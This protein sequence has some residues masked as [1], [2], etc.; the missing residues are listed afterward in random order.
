MRDI[1]S[2]QH[3]ATPAPA[4][5]L[6]ILRQAQTQG[7]EVL[8]GLRAMQT[9]AFPGATV[10]PGGKLE[11]EDRAWPDADDALTAGK[12]AALRETF[13]ETG[14][15]ITPDGDAPRAD[16]APGQARTQ[17]E[18]GLPRFADVL[19][20]HGSAAALSRLT[21]FAHWITPDLAPYRFDTLFFIVEA[22]PAEAEASLICAEFDTLR[23]ARPAELLSTK[24]TRLMTPTRHCLELLAGSETPS[25]AV[26]A[27]RTRGV[28]DGYAV[29][30]A[31]IA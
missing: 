21:P 13:E 14:L 15:L 6:I 8:V 16:A 30:T 22:S 18:S 25:H 31:R 7:L 2:P 12:Y 19:Q 20:S 29:R 4:A 9:R 27:A 11:D 1:P 3:R 23:W 5:S 24:A 26:H 28:V 17:L 10:F